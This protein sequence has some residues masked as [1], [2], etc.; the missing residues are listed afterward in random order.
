MNRA[1]RVAI[2]VL[3]GGGAGDEVLRGYGFRAAAVGGDVEPSGVA[4]GDVF[5]RVGGGYWWA[6]GNASPLEPNG[7]G[8]GARVVAVFHVLRDA[9][10]EVLARPRV[11]DV[12]NGARAAGRVVA[13]NGN[14]VEGVSVTEGRSAYGA[15]EGFNE[16]VGIRLV[17][18]NEGV[19][20][21][22]GLSRGEGV[23]DNIAAEMALG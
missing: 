13:M 23:G 2:T 21:G 20:D 15:G 16:V 1:A 8:P 12:R 14:L 9:E 7:G 6:R 11:V 4:R 3:R 18:I 22:D 5:T 10:Q 19:V 17:V